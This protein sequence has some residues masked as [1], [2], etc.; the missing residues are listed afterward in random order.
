MLILGLLLILV[1]GLLFAFGR[2]PRAHT[3]ALVL[4]VLGAGLVVIDALDV[5]LIDAETDD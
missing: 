2:F 1:A 4:L 5:N 3:V